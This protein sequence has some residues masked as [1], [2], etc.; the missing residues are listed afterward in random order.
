VSA[1]SE[2]VLS[3]DHEVTFYDDEAHLIDELTEFVTDGLALGEAV[4][5]VATPQHREALTASLSAAGC[6]LD[7][8]IAR[9]QCHVADAADTI[10]TFLQDDEPQP[11]LFFAHIGGLLESVAR[12]GRPVRVFG[13]MVALLWQQGNVSAAIS[14]ES[15]W[16]RL[17][18]VQQF[19]LLCAYP[20]AS[21]TE[22]GDLASVRAVCDVHSEVLPPACYESGE[23]EA[24][25]ADGTAET[26]VFVAALPAIRAVRHL[27]S[28]TLRA[29]GHDALVPDAEVLVTEL[30]TNAV[31][32]ALSPFRA[33]VT[34]SETSVR[35]AI[36]DLGVTMPELRPADLERLG[37]RGVA[38][39]DAMSQTWG[40][41]PAAAGKV[42]WC[43]LQIAADCRAG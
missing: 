4:V 23:S 11:H 34:R 14:L 5:L 10:A 6:S 7:D 21:L 13:E 39:V 29:W 2:S 35:I 42:V 33:S 19:S 38:L 36:E 15:L 26:R 24:I 31:R 32:H 18:E 22:S 40:C 12:S 37:G 41:E 20:T 28:D 17:A 9:G 43:E 16:N 27:V 1:L 3:H 8:A 30:A 25:A